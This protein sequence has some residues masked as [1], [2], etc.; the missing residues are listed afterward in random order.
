MRSA[1]STDDIS[2][3]TNSVGCLGTSCVTYSAM[4]SA[5]AVL[6][7]LGR[8]GQDDQLRFVQSAGHGVEIG[9]PGLDAADGVLV[10]IRASI[11]DHRVVQNILDA[12]DVWLAAAAVEDGEDLLF[13]LGRAFRADRAIAS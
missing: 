1:N 7:M 10:F 8:A 13:G 9:E 5:S 4:F 6:P 11:R 12:A 3:L 2:R